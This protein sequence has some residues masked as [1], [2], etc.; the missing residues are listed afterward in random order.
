MVT[1]GLSIAA[2]VLCI[3][4]IGIWAIHELPDTWIHDDQRIVIDEVVG[5]WMTM[6]G[7]PLTWPWMLAG[8]VLFRI[9]D[10]WKPLGIRQIDRMGGAQSVIVDDLVAGVYANIVL[11]IAYHTFASS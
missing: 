7:L 1:H 3:S 8:F 6:I 4:G 11:Q 9:I 10:I 2:L 5:I